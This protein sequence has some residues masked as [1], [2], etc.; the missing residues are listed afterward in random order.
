MHLRRQSFIASG[1]LIL[2]LPVNLAIAE[3]WTII[4]AV[5]NAVSNHP[6]TLIAESLVE[7][8]RG[9]YRA[10]LSLPPPRLFTR[11][12]EIPSNSGFSN[13]QE[14]RIGISQDFD[15]PLRYIWLK[16]AGDR[17]VE[18]ARSESRA[19][20]LDLESDVR[21]LFLE[22]WA[23]QEEVKVRRAYRDSIT[24]YSSYIQEISDA[25]GFS[26]M[27]ARRTRIEAIQA[28]NELRASQRSMI[29]A[30]DRL[31]SATNCDLTDIELIS[32]LETDPVD[33]TGISQS[34]FLISNPEF[35]VAQSEVC[36]SGYEKTLA[37]TAWLPELELTYFQRQ[38]VD[39][40]NPD[41]WAVQLELTIPL[42]FWWGGLGEIKASKAK[43]KRAR[44]ELAAYQ[45]ELSSEYTK[46]LQ[47]LETACEEYELYHSKVLPLARDEYNMVYQNFPYGTGNYMD[48]I[49]AQDDMKDAQLEYIEKILN[50]YEKKIALDRLCGK[51]MVSSTSHSP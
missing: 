31:S 46:L 23:Y 21:L 18:R 25:G 14:R 42:W 35:L 2:L 45:L 49:N 4:D 50:L 39:P 10:S 15:F 34:D 43:L 16:K 27:D 44:A 22:A 32:P 33:T 9:E 1:I 41:I 36:I 19:I 12:D 26:Q 24:I 29:A 40:D 30:F 13:Y 11:Y 5:Q 48:L 6:E 17:S 51:S 47:E 3:S 28:D 37:T 20:L 38:E 8:A 7:E